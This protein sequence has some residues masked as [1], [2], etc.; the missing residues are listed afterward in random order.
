MPYLTI[1]DDQSDVYGGPGPNYRVLGQVC[2]GDR[3]PILGCSEDRKWWQVD[4]LGWPGWIAMQ[5]VTTDANIQAFPT[6]ETPSLPTN[7]APII[8]WIHPAPATVE[9]GNTI[10][11]TC[12]ASDPDGDALIYIWEAS[13]GLITGQ[14]ALIRYQAPE[15]IGIQTVTVTVQDGYGGE[16]KQS[17]QVQV[18]LAKPPAGKFDPIGIFGQIWH[19]NAETRQKLGWAT[20]EEIKTFGAQQLFQEGIVFWRQDLYLV[21]VLT[22]DGN[23]QIYES[24]W[25]ES[26]D[27]YSCST[28]APRTT[29]PIPKRH[30]G[31]VWCEQ[32][33][34]PDSA[35]GWASLSEKDYYARWQSFEHG[36]MWQGNDEYIYVFYDDGS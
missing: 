19:E 27:E 11:M 33:G 8:Q 4:Y 3:L 25:N 22:R 9:A 35:I 23:Y 31:K 17:M 18:T 15:I 24:D 2:R 1:D 26:M 16:A 30:I 34:G 12:Q 28:N 5:A 21:Y 29:P 20:R 14:D 13:D 10:T 32:L 6:V 7:H 36:L